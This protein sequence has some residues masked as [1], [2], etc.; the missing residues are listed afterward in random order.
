M[1]GKEVSNNTY[2]GILRGPWI[3]GIY[4]KHVRSARNHTLVGH[5]VHRPWPLE[6]TSVPVVHI[7]SRTYPFN[8]QKY[9]L[10]DGQHATLTPNII[11]NAPQ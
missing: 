11:L 6:A 8:K 5:D 9:A 10:D 3:T 4:A 7:H 1:K 2:D